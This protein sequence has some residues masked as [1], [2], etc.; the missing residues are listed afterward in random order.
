LQKDP[1]NLTY[2]H[3]IEDLKAGEVR[4]Y[5]R[6]KYLPK[7]EFLVS[8][9]GE[10]FRE[11]RLLDVG[12]GY[13]FWLSMLE[14]E[15]G[16]R[17]LHGM[18][19][20]P[21]SIEIASQM[22]SAKIVSGDITDEKW[23]FEPE[24]FDVVTCFDVVE[25]LEVPDDFFRMVRTVLKPGGTVVVTT[26]NLSLPYRMRSWPWIGIPEE[27]PTHINIQRPSYWRKLAVD[28]GFRILAQWRGEHLVH[29]R[30][31]PKLFRNICRWLRIDHRKV[32]LLNAFEQAFCMVLELPA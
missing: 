17:D 14:E 10:S 7:I 19:P 3:S 18:D 31:V 16:L 26:P 28:N 24:T 23:P 2:V 11:V 4:R 25:H 12:V 32:P 20:F 30:I 29:V 27:N 9:F 5:Q 6:E 22:T 15:Y 13:G 1:D 8:R 21:K